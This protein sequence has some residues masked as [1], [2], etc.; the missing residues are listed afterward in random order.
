MLE[1][2]LKGLVGNNLITRGK[3][4]KEQW[5]KLPALIKKHTCSNGQLPS[6]P[7]KKM[8]EKG[9]WKFTKKIKIKIIPTLLM[10]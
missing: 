2:D 4:S 1:T 8:R 5:L 9:F 10:L 3:E 6:P 7:G